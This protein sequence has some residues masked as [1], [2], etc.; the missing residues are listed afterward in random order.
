VWLGACVY[1]LQIIYRRL[2]NSFSVNL[3]SGIYCEFKR[4]RGARCS[5]EISSHSSTNRRSQ[6]NCY[7]L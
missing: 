3:D 4:I 2:I 5:P 7:L 1:G 6:G